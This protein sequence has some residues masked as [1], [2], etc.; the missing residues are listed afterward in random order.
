MN[1][2][3]KVLWNRSRSTHVVTD[4]TRTAHGKGRQGVTVVSTASR[5]GFAVYR[6]LFR[7]LR[8]DVQVLLKRTESLHHFE[9]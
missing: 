3:F 1:K 4:E 6:G 5:S 2:I 9:W 7:L 8:K